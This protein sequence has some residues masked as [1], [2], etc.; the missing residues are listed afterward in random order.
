MA[1]GLRGREKFL[2]TAVDVPNSIVFV[3]CPT[4]L[5]QLDGLKPMISLTVRPGSFS[6]MSRTALI[7]LNVVTILAQYVAWDR[8]DAALAM[9]I[10]R[11]LVRGHGNSA[12]V[13]NSIQRWRTIDPGVMADH[14][15]GERSST[16]V[17]QLGSGS[18]E[19]EDPH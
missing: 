6:S 19:I 16:P 14:I 1:T 10:H 9:A 12:L 15:V 18:V 7:L 17:I 13:A 8:Q 11:V 4:G 5:L 2:L 3:G